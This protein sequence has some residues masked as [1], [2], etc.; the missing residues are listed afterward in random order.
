M[1]FDLLTPPEGPRGRGKKKFDVACPI[2]V[3]NSHTKFGWISSNGLGGDSITD[4]RTD[5]VAYNI[6]FAFLKKRGDNYCAFIKDAVAVQHSDW[7][8]AKWDYAYCCKKGVVNNWTIHDKLWGY[9][10]AAIFWSFVTE[11]KFGLPL[12]SSGV[13]KEFEMHQQKF[14]WRKLESQAGKRMCTNQKLA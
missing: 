4:R 8:R 12:S 11:A 7:P 10:L 9:G 3:S 2:H 14:F 5:G 1:I 13:F 6:P